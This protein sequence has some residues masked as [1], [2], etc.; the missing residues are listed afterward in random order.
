VTSYFPLN[1]GEY[2]QE[3]IPMYTNMN[4]NPFGLFEVVSINYFYAIITSTNRVFITGS[5]D[6]ESLVMDMILLEDFGDLNVKSVAFDYKATNKVYVLLEDSTIHQ[7]QFTFDIDSKDIQFNFIDVVQTGLNVDHIQFF[8]TYEQSLIVITNENFHIYKLDVHL[9]IDE[10]I[11]LENDQFLNITLADMY[12][13]DLIH[14]TIHALSEDG[15]EAYVELNS[16]NPTISIRQHDLSLDESFVNIKFIDF[17]GELSVVGFT[18]MNRMINLYNGIS[19]NHQYLFSYDEIVFNSLD[20]YDILLTNGDII[21]YDDEVSMDFI[22][23]S[24]LDV[25]EY[26]DNATIDIIFENGYI[27]LSDG[28]YIYSKDEI[29]FEVYRFLDLEASVYFNSNRPEINDALEPENFL[30]WKTSLDYGTTNITE[31][32]NDSMLIYAIL[33]K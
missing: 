30:Y 22:R 4:A 16:S 8:R 29:N 11:N 3:I 32:P 13:E 21:Y 19:Y 28:R 20:F 27:K 23:E 6:N 18:D 9:S 25:E 12:Y 17:F 10:K 7:Y 24:Y 2:I 15:Y 5:H 1:E 33:D 31:L 14:I 26:M